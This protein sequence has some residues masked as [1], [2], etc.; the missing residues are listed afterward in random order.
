MATQKKKRAPRRSNPTKPARALVPDLNCINCGRQVGSGELLCFSCRAQAMKDTSDPRWRQ[1]MGV[2][3]G[4]VIPLPPEVANT[5]HELSQ[6]TIGDLLMGVARY[7]SS[8][9]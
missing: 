8:R 4:V 7:L 6:L 9:R 3:S 5:I 2:P 1:A